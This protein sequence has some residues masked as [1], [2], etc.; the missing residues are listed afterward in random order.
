MAQT[1]ISILSAVGGLAGVW[2]VVWTIINLKAR[3]RTESAAATQA[4]AEASKAEADAD[5]SVGDNWRRYAEKLET[6]QEAND[7][8]MAVLSDKVDG[9]R[10]YIGQLSVHIRKMEIGYCDRYD[11]K[12]RHPKMGDYHSDIPQLQCA[13]KDN[14]KMAK[15]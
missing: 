15:Q 10:E 9:L 2:A 4:E 12:D 14:C 8:K 3:K 1:I 11:C 13:A 5:A 7:A 6:R